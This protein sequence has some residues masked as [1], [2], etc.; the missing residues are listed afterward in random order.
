MVELTVDSKLA[1]AITG[2]E[3][4]QFFTLENKHRMV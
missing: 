1:D 3:F 2:I 4:A